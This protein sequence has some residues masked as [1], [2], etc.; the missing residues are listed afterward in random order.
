MEEGETRI[1]FLDKKHSPLVDVMTVSQIIDKHI[2]WGTQYCKLLMI[3]NSSTD[4][5][6]A[7]PFSYEFASKVMYDAVRSTDHK[8]LE[9]SNYQRY[10]AL[11]FNSMLEHKG[12]SYNRAFAEQHGLQGYL[13]LP[14]NKEELPCY[15]K[16]KKL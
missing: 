4:T 11:Q 8:I 12:I 6:T 14:L 2:P 3:P 15:Y 1:V 7:F 13:I 16:I 5:V 9:D 10:F